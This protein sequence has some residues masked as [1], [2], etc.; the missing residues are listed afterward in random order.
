MAPW[1]DPNSIHNLRPL[2]GVTSTAKGPAKIYRSSVPGKLQ[3]SAPELCAVDGIGT[4]IDLREPEEILQR[5]DTLPEHVGYINIPLYRGPVPRD[6]PI[7]QVYSRLITQ[8]GAQLVCVLKAVTMALDD[9]VLIHCTAGK[10]RTGLVAALVLSV[11]GIHRDIIVADYARSADELPDS[12]HAQVATEMSSQWD[13]S[14]EEFSQA[15]RLHTL[16]PASAMRHL[17]EHLDHRYGSVARFLDCVGFSL[18]EQ[19]VLAEHLHARREPK[20]A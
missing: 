5:P 12:Y 2:P 9:G 8:R 20:G 1:G 6:E 18:P 7:L 17:L 10:D 19:R 16:S 4:V 11:A 14:S 3:L 15:L 13:T